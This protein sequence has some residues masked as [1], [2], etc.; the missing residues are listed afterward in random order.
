MRVSRVLVLLAA[1]VMVAGAL[2][3]GAAPA[4]PQ[5]GRQ[6]GGMRMGGG[7]GIGSGMLMMPELQKE[8]KITTAQKA[9][10]DKIIKEM[11]ALPRDKMNRESMQKYQTRITGVLSQWQKGRL[12]E[13]ELQSR[14]GSALLDPE[15]QKSLGITAAQKTKLKSIQDASQKEMR[16]KFEAAR[17][18]EKPMDMTAM[19]NLRKAQDAKYMAQLSASQKAK[20]KTMTGKPFAMPAIRARGAGR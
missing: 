6:G 20:W 5:G 12:K 1:L 4:R 14:G 11:Q 18:S 9:S 19:Q 2:A 8:L 13:I 7:G 16:A 15:V 3:Q 17:K 10:I